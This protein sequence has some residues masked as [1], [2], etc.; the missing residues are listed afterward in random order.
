MF[1]SFV[2]R[3]GVG[4]RNGN[5]NDVM[6]IEILRRNVVLLLENFGDN[7]DGERNGEVVWGFIFLLIVFVNDI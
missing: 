6:I 2:V 7:F 5:L 3:N 1:N 4:L